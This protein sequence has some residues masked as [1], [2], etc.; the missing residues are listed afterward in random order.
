MFK[1]KAMGDFSVEPYYVHPNFDKNGFSFKQGEPWV[2]EVICY[3]QDKD[4]KEGQEKKHLLHHFPYVRFSLSSGTFSLYLILSVSQNTSESLLFAEFFKKLED[5]KGLI[6]LYNFTQSRFTLFE[7]TSFLFLSSK[8]DFSI[9]NTLKKRQGLLDTLNFLKNELQLLASIKD[10]SPPK[11][12]LS[13]LYFFS[14]AKK[15]EEVFRRLHKNYHRY[16][17]FC[18]EG[19][20]NEFK[21]LSVLSHPTFDI[22]RS[23]N[24]LYRLALLL[25]LIRRT[26][27][28]EVSCSSKPYQ[29]IVKPFP[30]TLHFP[31][32]SKQALGMVI[33][34]NLFNPGALLKQ[35][36]LLLALQ[37]LL[38][39][40]N[41]IKQS[42]Y[43]DNDTEGPTKL[44]YIEIDKNKKSHFKPSEILLIKKKLPG[45]LQKRVEFLVPSLFGICSDTEINKN[46]LISQKD[47]KDLSETPQVMIYFD[48]Q[49]VN[50]IFFKVVMIGTCF[51]KDN[52]I[53]S[54]VD[55]KKDLIKVSTIKL[56][57]IENCGKHFRQTWI[58]RIELTVSSD[59]R[60]VN[61]SIN[62]YVAREK[63]VK[64]LT[65]N[66]GPIQD[67]NGSIF[68]KQ[69]QLFTKLK[70][71]FSHIKSH[72]SMVEDFF[73]GLTSNKLQV[74]C[75]FEV[76]KCG[77]EMVQKALSAPSLDAYQF[78]LSCK[79]KHQWE[80]ICVSLSNFEMSSELVKWLSFS[81]KLSD[82]YFT[83][84]Q[85][86]D[87][88]FLVILYPYY[89]DGQKYRFLNC[90]NKKLNSSRNRIKS[91]QIFHLSVTHLPYSLDPRLSGDELS[92]ALVK[93][94]FEGLLRMGKKGKVQFGIAKHFKASKDLKEYTFYL[95]D[96]YWSNGE[97]VC[98]YD[99]EYTWKKLLSPHFSSP[100]SYFLYPIKNAKRISENEIDVKELGIRAVGD[101]EL[102]IQ[103]EYP[104]SY[105]LDLVTYSLFYPINHKI[106]KSSYEFSQINKHFVCNGPFKVKK[107]HS[108]YFEFEKNSHYWDFS[109]VNLD[110]ITISQIPMSFSIKMF[111]K[112]QIDW[113]GFPFH[114]KFVSFSG[115]KSFASAHEAMTEI[116]WYVCNINHP[117]LRNVKLRQALA[118]ALDRNKL[119]KDLSLNGQAATSILNDQQ[120][121]QKDRDLIQGNIKKAQALFESFLEETELR[122]ET[123][124]LFHVAIAYG[125]IQE[126]MAR[127]IAQMW[128][129]N[130]GIRI[131]IQP[132][133]WKYLFNKLKNRQYEITGITWNSWVNDPLYTL[134]IF[135]DPN[136]P[137]NFSSW[138]NE[139]FREII[140]KSKH[141]PLSERLQLH[142]CLE[143]RLLQEFPVIPILFEKNSYVSSPYLKGFYAAEAGRIDFKYASKIK[144]FHPD[145]KKTI[146]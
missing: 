132:Y 68:V 6:E 63:I 87:A 117:L 62:L 60:H 93:M 46:I 39:D 43:Q 59:L 138:F 146:F 75:P 131:Y 2:E 130:L 21:R 13:D 95:R 44:F 137:I 141:K 31:F 110:R 126:K 80:I 136:H 69:T 48:H 23:P 65:D 86:E 52:L 134:E 56:Q 123:L 103:L 37:E 91:Q 35:H 27:Q 100:F 32:E 57:G 1:K 107:F 140:E 143:N 108:N 5:Y 120:A 90:L 22:P 24:H 99:F 128:E 72:A 124:P 50:K 76:L 3:L 142:A 28:I 16:S 98:A 71:H 49:L 118:Y 18:D 83:K 47:S 38:G 7:D 19:I 67:R 115:Y 66:L 122:V 127:I 61:S 30:I 82:Y 33:G 113:L 45:I 106:N 125:E 20:I 55:T 8:M 58:L 101:K 14:K 102:L 17:R 73:Y 144:N 25:Y 42:F 74:D 119:I 109:T 88:Y 104:Y 111:D 9:L 105:F 29:G 84:I 54:L 40:V 92:S 64:F 89:K 51:S 12:C 26:L 70:E 34:V 133:E 97:P 85:N 4:R 96:C 77:F 53:K 81:N 79:S 135:Q 10:F 139:E 94:L 145:D 36:H 78:D 15:K 129:K 121:Q 41:D 116:S 11:N 112:G 114:S